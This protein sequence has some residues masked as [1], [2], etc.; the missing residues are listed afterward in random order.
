MAA[1]FIKSISIGH[2]TK[3]KKTIKEKSSE[4][5]NYKTVCMHM[6]VEIAYFSMP[7]LR[8]SSSSCVQSAASGPPYLRLCPESAG[9]LDEPVETTTEVVVNIP[10]LASIPVEQSRYVGMPPEALVAT[11]V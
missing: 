11:L 5:N 2:S 7:S 3:I 9:I 10:T 6:I 4:R 1:S 8:I